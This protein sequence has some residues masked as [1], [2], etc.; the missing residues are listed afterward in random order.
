M[1]QTS[2]T[3]FYTKILNT[4]SRINSFKRSSV[5]VDSVGVDSK[6]NYLWLNQMWINT[7]KADL[8]VLLFIFETIPNYDCLTVD[9]QSSNNL[10]FI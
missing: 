10:R 7:N 9:L 8:Y 2:T 3:H 6:G 1:L 4:Y 5:L